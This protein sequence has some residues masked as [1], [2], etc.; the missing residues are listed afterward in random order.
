M[1]IDIDKKFERIG[2]SRYN[3]SMS[4][5]S[6]WATTQRAKGI[7]DAKRGKLFSKL[8]RQISIATK[9]GGG[10]DLDSNYKLRIIVDT[11]RAANMPKENIERAISKGSG[12]GESLSEVVY[13]GFGPGGVGLIIKA[14]TDNKNR[15][16]QEIKLLLER[17]GGSFAGPG[18]VSFN[19]KH[20]GNL[21]VE[22]PIDVDSVTLT[23]IDAGATDVVETEAGLDVFTEPHDL[24]EVKKKAEAAGITF[25]RAELIQRPI[26]MIEID[27]ATGEKLMSLLEIIE[28]QD[29]VDTVYMNA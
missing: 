12:E 6:H 27:E 22:K 25:S 29:D 20:E 13:E 8:A 19:F 4:G 28:D 24:Y 23:L 26:T 14:T 15:T 16:A 3:L 7:K 1:S 21:F 17:N 18:A 11:A 5:H 10:T 9:E 2:E